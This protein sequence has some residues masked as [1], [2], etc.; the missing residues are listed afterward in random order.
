MRKSF[1]KKH[2][3]LGMEVEFCDDGSLKL[4]Q[5]DYIKEAIEDFGEDLGRKA[6]NPAGKNCFKVDPSATKLDEPKRKRFHSIVQK[7]LWVTKRSRPDIMVPISFL[8]KRVTKATGQDWQKLRIVLSYLENTMDMPLIL[9]IDN[10]S[11]V[12]TWVDVAFAVHE[13]YKSHTGNVISMGKGALY[14]RSIGQKLNTTS[15]TE[16]ELVGASDCLGQTI[17]TMNF[18]EH[19]GIKVRRNYYYQD[20]ESAIRL[21]KNGIQ[22]ASK[23]SRHIDIRFFFIKDRIKRGDIHLLYCPTEDML[24]DFFSKP[25]QGK[26][27]IRFRDMIMGHAP[28]PPV[29]DPS[30]RDC[31][32]QERVG[33][34]D[35]GADEQQTDDGSMTKST[36]PKVTWADLVR[37]V[38]PKNSNR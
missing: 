30:P 34:Q 2:T 31:A 25:L 21:E 33:S 32:A 6:P 12:K 17:W 8:T 20:N 13:D 7:L 19:Q 10:L 38:K 26:L 37:G 18:L 3:Y 11:I 4:S 28:L 24:A 35:F 14:A 29:V 36:I 9:K 27:F 22:S 16:S 15:T 23:R 1:G 5:I